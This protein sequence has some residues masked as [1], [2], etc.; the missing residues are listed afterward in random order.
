MKPRQA[1]LFICLLITFPTAPLLAQTGPTLDTLLAPSSLLPKDR[2]LTNRLE[3][4]QFIQGLML[5]PLDLVQ[6]NLG[7]L[8]LSNPGSDPIGHYSFRIRATW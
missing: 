3:S 8:S 4:T 6:G 2:L 7:A 1:L 5:H